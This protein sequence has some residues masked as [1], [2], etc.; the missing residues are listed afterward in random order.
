MIENVIF[1]CICISYQFLTEM[2]P[3]PWRI[4]GDKIPQVLKKLEKS[5]KNG[6][7]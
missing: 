5:E 6:F 2:F 1:E 4:N 3:C 7:A